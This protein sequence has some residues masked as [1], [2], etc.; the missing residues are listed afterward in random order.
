VKA[1]YQIIASDAL[2]GQAGLELRHIPGPLPTRS[3]IS[4][5]ATQPSMVG[6]SC[7]PAQTTASDD[8]RLESGVGQTAF[9]ISLEPGD[10]VGQHRRT[11][12]SLAQVF[13]TRRAA[14]R[15]RPF[16]AQTADRYRSARADR[17]R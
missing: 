5:P 13:A 12:Q 3:S 14:V 10:L 2:S 17:S 9:S 15:T 11:S 4:R 7:V 16:G 8:R 1:V 6:R